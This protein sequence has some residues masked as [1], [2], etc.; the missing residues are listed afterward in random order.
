MMSER[1][2]TWIYRSSR[3]EE[4]YLYLKKEG[5]FDDVPEALMAMFG[6]PTLVMGLEL[7]PERTL[8]REDSKVVLKS[9]HEQGFF[10]QM[11]PKLE[12]DLYDGPQ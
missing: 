6:E 1:V 7:T 12:P 3:K 2:H 11:P 9:L 5:A 4:M 8:A 10:L